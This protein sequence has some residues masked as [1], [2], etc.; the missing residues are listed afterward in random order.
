MKKNSNQIAKSNTKNI[1]ITGIRTSNE[2]LMKGTALETE[3]LK[4][5]FFPALKSG[6]C[7]TTQSCY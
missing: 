7:I 5:E 4:Y 2:E 1:N 6:V 3:K